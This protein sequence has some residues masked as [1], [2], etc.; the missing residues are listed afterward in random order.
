M[1]PSKRH[2]FLRVLLS[3]G[4]FI[5]VVAAAYRWEQPLKEWVQLRSY[6]PPSA[7]VALAD[8]TTMTD[9]AR[10]LF[11]LNKPAVLDRAD[12]N[13]N[14]PS[15]TEKTIVLGCYHGVQHG[16]YIF[17]VTDKQLHGV[18]QVTAAHEMLHAAYDHLSGHQREKVN[19]MLLDYYNHHL[20]DTRI[21]SVLQAYKKSEPNDLVNEM[22]SIFGTEVM[23][24]PSDLSAYYQQY[25]KD[26]SAVVTFANTYRQAFTDRENKIATYDVQLSALERQI[27]HNEALLKQ[28]SQALQN[29][30]ASVQSSTDQTV[31]DAYSQRV[32]DYNA[33]LSQ[34]NDLVDRYNT[35][36][37]TRNAIALQEKQLQQSLNSNITPE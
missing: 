29:D 17:S 24:L 22:H 33:L 6:A 21:R 27:T 11:Y 7:I 15:A 5:A 19:A 4:V 3:L 9:Q 18:E 25:F 2:S 32:A 1:E 35:I 12:F 20:Q 23:D 30:R 8:E 26:R 36:A 10:R 13:Q 28:Q 37:A 16:I 34:T 31:V 14:C